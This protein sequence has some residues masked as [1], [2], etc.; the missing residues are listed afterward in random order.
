MIPISFDSFLKPVRVV[1]FPLI[2][3]SLTAI[4]LG[5]GQRPV[6]NEGQVEFWTMQ[7]QPKFTPYFEAVNENFEALHDDA[8]VVWVDV[9]WDAMESRILTAVSANNAPDVVNLNP[10]FASQLAARN[11]WLN[12]EEEISEEIRGE[13]LSQI[14][15]ANQIEICPSENDCTTSTFGI[16]WYLTT[17]VTVYNKDL[18][19]QAGVDSPPANFEELAEV[20]QRVKD[21]TGKYA[22]FITFVPTDSNEVLNSLVQMGVTLLD[23][24]GRAAF[25]TPEGERA[26]SYWVDLYQRDLLP[27]E[28]FTQGHR[29]GVELYQAG[30]SAILGTG[31]EFLNTIATNAPTVYEQSAVAPQ[32]TGETGKRSVS[33]MNLVIPRSSSN[34]QQAINYAL[35]VTNSENQLNFAQE[36][37]VLPSHTGAIATYIENLE[38]ES[39]ENTLFEARKISAMQL[40]SAEVLIPPSPNINQLKRIIYENLQSAMLGEKTVQ[41]ALNDAETQ[42]NNL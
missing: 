22:F 14:W 19:E 15:A 1:R 31:A 34:P 35:F 8:S 29:H 9:P 33:V 3:G 18:L 5:C 24:E 2:V 17:T 12:L 13:Y 6:A 7:L 38:Q 37:N 21:E 42:W 27:P 41:Q 30:E 4:L 16:P 36:A 32:I 40:D 20:A 23:G 10:D 28:V 25:N 26:F 39:E 11:A